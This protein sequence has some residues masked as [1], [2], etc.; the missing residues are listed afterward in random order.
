[1]KTPIRTTRHFAAMTVLALLLTATACT[2][3]GNDGPG[4]LRI[5]PAGDVLFSAL[6]PETYPFTVAA[7]GEWEVTVS[8]AEAAAWCTAERTEEGFTLKATVNDEIQAPVEATVTVSASNGAE[9]VTFTARQRPLEIWICGSVYD[10]DRI[11]QMAAYWCNGEQ[12]LLTNAEGNPAAST[13]ANGIYVDG[14]DVYAAGYFY[15][16]GGIT[17]GVYWECGRM[18]TIQPSDSYG[19]TFLSDICLKN[20]LTCIAGRDGTIGNT[21]AQYWFDGDSYPLS[22]EGTVSQTDQMFTDGNDL[23]I[24]GRNDTMPGYWKNGSFVD[25]SYGGDASYVTALLKQGDDIYAAG[26][27]TDVDKYVPLWWKNGEAHPLT[28]NE[29]A[30]IYGMWVNGEDIYLAGSS[31]VVF[32]RAA[33]YWKNGEQTLLTG[34][35]NGCLTCVAAVGEHIYAVGF[36]QNAAGNTV[37]KLWKDGQPSDWTDGATPAYAEGYFIR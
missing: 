1:M 20:G 24:V 34:K 16:P 19:S 14:D 25:L 22:D 5:T 21:I 4:E 9:P 29:S 2:D 37:I 26:Q 30:N 18:S 13:I 23:Y 6:H 15:L 12:T 32:D 11:R 31:G 17:H 35:N 28:V 8:P 27:Y 36:E 33:A 7:D 10:A 3:D